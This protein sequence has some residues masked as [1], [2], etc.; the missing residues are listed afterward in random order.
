V[1]DA[2]GSHEPERELRHAIDEWE[3]AGRPGA[4]RLRLE[5]SY[6]GARPRIRRRW[7]PR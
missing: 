1:L 7:E 4:D 3:R 6:A 5:V 2:H